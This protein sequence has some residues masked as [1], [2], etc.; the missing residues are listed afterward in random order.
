MGRAAGTAAG[1]RQ[2]QRLHPAGHVDDP[3]TDDRWGSYQMPALGHG[4]RSSLS[5]PLRVDHSV[6]GALNLY[7]TEPGAF[8]AAEQLASQRFADEAARALGLAV[9]LAEHAEMS[10]D[11]RDALASRAVIDQALGIIMGQRRCTGDAA[12]AGDPAHSPARCWRSPAR[13]AKRDLAGRI[14]R[15]CVAGLAVDGAAIS[16]FTAPGAGD[17][18]GHRRD[19]GAV[20]GVA[21]R[22]ARGPVPDGRDPRTSRAGVGPAESRGDR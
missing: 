10:A 15:A 19:R 1:H 5:L 14:C 22:G 13:A 8:G 6:I 11:L 3:A 7:A 18:V 9:R 12:F 16:V 17:A 20:G 2:H 4:V 21:V